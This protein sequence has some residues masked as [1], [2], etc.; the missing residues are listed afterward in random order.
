MLMLFEPVRI[1]EHVVYT[2]SEFRQRTQASNPSQTG[3]LCLSLADLWAR[4]I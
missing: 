1:L 4:I 2:P 3:Q